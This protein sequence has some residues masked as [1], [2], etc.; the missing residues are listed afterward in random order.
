M[1]RALVRRL[2]HR[3]D[4]A[5]LLRFDG[6]SLQYPSSGAFEWVSGYLSKSGTGYSSSL[7][8]ASLRPVTTASIYVSTTGND[9]TGNGTSVNPYRTITKA[10]SVMNQATTVYVAVGTYDH[11]RHFQGATTPIVNYDCEFIATGGRVVCTTSQQN[12]VWTPNGTYPNVY[13]A[14]RSAVYEVIDED[15]SEVNADGLGE[16]LTVQASVADVD[17]NPGSWYASG[18]VVYVRTGDS[19]APD[20]NLHVTLNVNMVAINGASR[21]VYIENF[22]FKGGAVGCVK[23]T[24]CS[25]LVLNGCTLRYAQTNG[26][27]ADATTDV[28][29]FN[30]TADENELDGFNYTTVTRAFEYGCTARGNGHDGGNINNGSSMHSGGTIVRINGTYSRNSGINVADVGDGKSWLLGCTMTDTKATASSG[31]INH[32]TDGQSWLDGC[33]VDDNTVD[34]NADTG[35]VI[36]VRDTSYATSG[37]GGSIGSY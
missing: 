19:R 37:G 9:T 23:T 17:A 10:I 24:A 26:L 29:C 1:R 20:A 36:Y 16:H 11:N 13:Q 22:D 21:I 4:R 18:G 14:T 28:Y 27:D 15:A 6:A 7:V 30:T 3:L 32:Y 34:L 5:G 33:T 12:L 35:A 8:P 31:Q 25:R 2:D